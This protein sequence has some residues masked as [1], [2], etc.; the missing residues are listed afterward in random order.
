MVSCTDKIMNIPRCVKITEEVEIEFVVKVTKLSKD[1][2][3]EI[4]RRLP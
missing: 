1:K 3:E 2:V 4:R